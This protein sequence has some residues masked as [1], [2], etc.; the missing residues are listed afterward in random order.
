MGY[1]KSNSN[2]VI[3]LSLFGVGAV[4][5]PANAKCI[6]LDDSVADAINRMTYPNNVLEKVTPKITVED[7]VI[8]KKPARQPVRQPIT[9][10]KEPKKEV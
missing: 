8:V 5:I 2:N 4:H 1:Y 7:E 3:S 9:V 10:T 6:D